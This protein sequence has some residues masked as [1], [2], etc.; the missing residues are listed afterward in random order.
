M[1]LIDVVVFGLKINNM[2]IF[3]TGPLRP[4]IDSFSKNLKNIRKNF[5]GCQI[6]LA[7]WKYI[8]DVVITEIEVQKLKDVIDHLLIIDEP[9]DDDIS[10][11]IKAKTR[12]QSNLPVDDAFNILAT[13]NI[14]KMFFAIKK[15][16]EYVDQKE[17]LKNCDIVVRHRTDLYIDLDI[18]VFKDIN[19]YYLYNRES[20]GVS[21]DDWFS[22]SSYDNFKKVW[23]FNNTEEYENYLSK[24][25][26]AEDI[27][28]NKVLDNKI[29]YVY[30]NIKEVYLMRDPKIWKTDKYLHKKFDEPEDI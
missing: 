11:L 23:Y 13:Y 1:W 22:I 18:E 10:S 19:S 12:Q 16:V 17:I 2:N 24:S 28:K 30:L 29:N 6:F 14:Y 9:K 27:I 25:W 7:T 8:E 26:N 5:P 4:N 15:L 21:F 3:L 20:S